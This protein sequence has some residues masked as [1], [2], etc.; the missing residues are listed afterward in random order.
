M[1][2]MFFEVWI[3]KSLSEEERRRVVKKLEEVCKEVYEVF[4]DYDYIVRVESEDALKIEGISYRRHYD[5]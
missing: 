4:Y 1:S 5:C 3:K 2:S